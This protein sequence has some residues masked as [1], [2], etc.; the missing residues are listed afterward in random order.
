MNSMKKVFVET[1][2]NSQASASAL[3]IINELK[4]TLK[5]KMTTIRI[6]ND[7]DKKMLI[8]SQRVIY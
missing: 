5:S 2:C 7:V 4:Q 8:E 1:A 3:Q 6:N